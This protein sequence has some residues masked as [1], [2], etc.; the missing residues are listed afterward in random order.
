MIFREF[1]LNDFDEVRKLYKNR[2]NFDMTKEFYDYL[3]NVNNRYC[4]VVCEED[5]KVVAHNAIIPKKY[6][7]NDFEVTIGLSSG[8]MV[9]LN[10]SGVFFKLL[11][12]G[13]KHFKGQGIIAF[14][15]KN[16]EPFFT[17]LL[18]FNVIKENYFGVKAND[19]NKEFKE[20]YIIQTKMH[21]DAFDHRICNH[22]KNLYLKLSHN[23][24]FVIYKEFGEEIDLIYISAFNS[25]LVKILEGLFER[26]FKEINLICS[27]QEIPI[28]MGFSKKRNNV[29]T[30][31]WLDKNFENV[32]FNCQM[33]DSDVF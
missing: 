31:K 25:D 12:Y 27:N 9:D 2:L 7:V 8:G 4:S 33:L 17:K 29:F 1:T 23:D 3:Y 11:K 19:L 15:N 32:E 24:T 10:Y 20:G 14:P 30:Y 6:L 5:G 28:S 16:S 26:G 18:K 21:Q 22:P 13:I